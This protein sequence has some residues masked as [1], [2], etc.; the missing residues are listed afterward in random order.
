MQL[1]WTLKSIPELALLP[2]AERQRLWRAAY[3]RASGHW[4]MWAGMFGTGLCAAIG[5]VIGQSIG[6]LWVGIISGAGIGGIIHGQ[7]VVDLTRRYL[8]ALL[9]TAA[10]GGGESAM[11]P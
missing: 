10:K 8:P 2:P 7:I 4:L 11:E 3:S 6:W 9:L 5:L 1:Y